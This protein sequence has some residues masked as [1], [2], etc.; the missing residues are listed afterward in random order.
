MFS[1]MSYHLIPS[2]LVSCPVISSQLIYLISSHLISSHPIPSLISYLLSY[3]ISSHHLI[4]SH[5]ISS[6]LISNTLQYA[7]CS[8]SPV[9]QHIWLAGR[10]W[11]KLIAFLY[12]CQPSV[13]LWIGHVSRWPLLGLLILCPVCKSSHC[14]SF[15]DWVPVDFIYGYPILRW[16]SD[17]IQWLHDDV[18]KWKHFPRYWPFVRGIPV[19]SPHKGQWHRALMFSLICVWINGWVNNRE[20]G[21]V[22]RYR[23]HYD[24]TIMWWG[25]DGTMIMAPTVAIGQHTLLFRRNMH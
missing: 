3:L 17:E 12:I 8:G 6:H 13:L 14:I 5:L 25:W 2:Y 9:P 18:I 22:R 1:H 16:D 11:Y 10:R 15:E 7:P 19:N 4:S 20:A 24:V 23:A 21:D